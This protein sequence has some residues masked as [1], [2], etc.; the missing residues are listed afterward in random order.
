MTTYTAALE[1][2]ADQACVI[3]DLE[4]QLQSQLSGR[5]Y[6]LQLILQDGMLII[7]GR[8][9]TYYGKQ[10]VLSAV[11]QATDVPVLAN[12]IEVD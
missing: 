10:L 11:M 6:D 8:S 1:P 5:I 4:I 12:D 7:R 3:E 2:G 9:H